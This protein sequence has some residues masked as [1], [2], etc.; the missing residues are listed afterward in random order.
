MGRAAIKFPPRADRKW[1]VSAVQ[2]QNYRPFVVRCSLHA[3]R[4]A[5][6]D[7]VRNLKLISRLR[8]LS[9]RSINNQIVFYILAFP[10]EITERT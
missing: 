2:V 3:A 1:Q 4:G 6:A 7:N 10:G 9:L 5:T 8:R